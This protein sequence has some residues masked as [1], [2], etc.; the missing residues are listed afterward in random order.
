MSQPV[1]SIIIPCYNSG[2]LLEETIKSIEKIYTPELHEVIIVNDGSTDKK[3]VE[4]LS[5]ISKHKVINQENGGLANARNTGIKNSAGKYLLFLDSDNL[6][7]EGYLKEGVNVLENDVNI[8]IVYGE[9]EKFGEERGRLNV[10]PFNLQTLM[11]Y[12]YIDACCLIR[13]NLFDDLGGFDEKMKV[14]GYEDWE[15]WIRAASHNKKFFYMEGVIV[16]KYRVL[17]SSMIRSV[18]K[19]DRDHVFEY[20]EKKYPSFLNFSG[21]SDFYYEKFRKQTL[22]WTTKLFLKKYIPSLYKILIRKGKLSK[23]L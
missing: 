1:V 18:N 21:V 8:D 23:Y 15:L 6:L 14:Q 20:L 7:T 12:N 16:Q 4:I 22:G 19:K 17:N 3:T 13:R 11:T 2:S 5:Q 10:I 9:S